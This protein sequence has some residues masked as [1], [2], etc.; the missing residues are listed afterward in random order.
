MKDDMNY[1]TDILGAFGFGIIAVL[2]LFAAI[3]LGAWWHLGTALMCSI[4]ADALRTEAKDE[5][6]DNSGWS[7][8]DD[9]MPYPEE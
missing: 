2:A 6:A 9:H 4:I 8:Q 1:T 5:K 3:A 7:K